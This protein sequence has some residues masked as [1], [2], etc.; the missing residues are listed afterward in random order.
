MAK[1]FLNLACGDFYLPSSDWTNLDWYPH[2]KYVTKTNLLRPL[3]FPNEH[4]DV[5]YTSHFIEHIP[6][7][8]VSD[9]L[10]ECRRVLKP[11]GVIRIVVPDFENI[12]REY[13][14]NLETD[15]LEYAEF[16]IIE[17]IDQCVRT[18]SGGELSSWRARPNISS[19]T[20]RYISS[21][22]GY[23]YKESLD[24]FKIEAK[25]VGQDFPKLVFRKLTNLYC[26][27]VL[28]MLPK[29][30]NENHVNL[31]NTGELHRWVYDSNTLKKI[32]LEVG[33]NQTFLSSAEK[34][35]I[36]E[37]PFF[38]LDIDESG[39]FRKGLESMYLEARK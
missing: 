23:Q 24:H 11:E 3:P 39:R 22:T 19:S 14:K 31:S 7:L 29:W 17:M 36:P 6:K 28:K 21:R 18:K 1:S 2:S 30:F 8:R 38:P 4:F 10:T 32:L 5:V 12:A 15:N 34:S 9:F 26:M 35:I 33:F 37:F 27:S 25:N 16:N 13:V 20:R